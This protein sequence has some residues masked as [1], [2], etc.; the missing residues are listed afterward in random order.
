M[1]NR[2]EKKLNLPILVLIFPNNIG[3]ITIQIS[4]SPKQELS[5]YAEGCSQI[6]KHFF[7]ENIT[8]LHEQLFS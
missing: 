2:S 6:I 7:E 8:Y 4:Y 1:Q 3:Y 5:S